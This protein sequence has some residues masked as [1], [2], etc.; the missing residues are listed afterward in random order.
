MRA[1][2]ND[3]HPDSGPGARHRRRRRTRR[4]GSALALAVL[5][6]TAPAAGTATVAAPP[7]GVLVTAQVPPGL[8]EFYAQ[9]LVWTACGVA[10]ECAQVQVPLDHENPAAGQIQSSA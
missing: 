9:Q 2:E 5:L 4:A 8:E 6:A 7:P 1:P 10:A 3:H